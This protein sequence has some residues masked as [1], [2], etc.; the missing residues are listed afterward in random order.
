MLI[1][2]IKYTSYIRIFF[3]SIETGG[4][5]PGFKYRSNNGFSILQSISKYPYQSSAWYTKK[6]IL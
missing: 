2:Y 5:D 3:I 1:P 6:R 4:Q